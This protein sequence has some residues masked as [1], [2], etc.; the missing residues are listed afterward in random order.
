MSVIGT[1]RNMRNFRRHR[2]IGRLAGAAVLVTCTGLLAAACTSSASSGSNSSANAPAFTTTASWGPTSWT[3]SPY[4]TGLGAPFTAFGVQLPLGIAEKTADQ[5]EMFAT[6][7]QLMSS[8]SVTSGNVATIHLIPGVKFSTGE[9]VNAADV[10]D[11]ILLRLVQQS[12]VWEDDIENVTAPNATTVVITFTPSTANVNVRGTIAS[13]VPQPMS[14]Y[15]QFLPAGIEP[16]L[17]A[18]NKLVQ[19]PK[20]EATAQSSPLFAKIDPYTKKLIVY[21]PSKLIGDG[22]FMITGVNTSNL[23]EVKSPSYFSASKVHVQKVALLNATSS[24]S[25][26]F[27]QLYSHDIDWY[28]SSPTTAPPSATEF[29][30]W[31]ATSDANTQTIPNNVVENLLINSQA[32]PFTLTPVRQAL[33]YLINRTTLTQTEDGGTLTANQP[34]PLPDGLGAILNDIWLTPSQRAQLNPY[35]YSPSKATALLQSAGFKKSGGHWLMPNGKQFTTQVIAATSPENGVLAAQDIAAQLT[36]F[37][38]SA[39]ASTVSAA[40]Y[41]SQYEKGDFQLAWQTGVNGNLEPICGIATGGL[42]SPTN[43]DFG[44]NGKDIPG[45]SG[46]GFG[47]G[48]DVPGI[49]TVPVSQTVDLECQDTQAGPRMA[50]LTWDWAQV[51]NTA[52]PFLSYADDDAMNLYS[53]ANYTNWPPA[54][55]VLWQYA[56]IATTQV[57]QPALL[58]M[59]EDGYISPRS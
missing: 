46:I 11:T 31:K 26:V 18:Y 6:V 22:P 52:V 19:N 56:G 48:Y 50:D 7:P 23:T 17:L 3:Y 33:A 40:G 57:A 43:Y 37:G 28:A 34:S 55:S 58:M 47:A 51:V 4:S 54:S 36:A 12:A 5:T 29:S 13:I 35:A 45:Q 25:S 10:V 24:G 38:I 27:A 14:Q 1:M 30:Q 44:S 15:G 42:G 16:T 9:P 20:T 8:Y 59:M 2:I 21:S 32:Y 39:T 53:T 49:G 41:Q